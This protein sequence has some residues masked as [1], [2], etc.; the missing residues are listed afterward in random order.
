MDCLEIYFD[1]ACQPD[2]VGTYGFV[3]TRGGRKL[4]GEGGVA[5]PKDCT[6]N[7]AEYTALVKALEKALELGADCIHIFGDSQ[8]VVRQIAGLYKVRAPHLKP[9]YARARELLQKFRHHEV[10][11]VPRGKNREADRYARRL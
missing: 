2:G 6:N 7:Y 8:L 1:G 4:Y 3:I 10:S 11:W 9:L 5:C